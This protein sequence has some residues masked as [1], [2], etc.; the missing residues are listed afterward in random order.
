[1]K[2]IVMAGRNVFRHT[3]RSVITALAISVGLAGM[4]AMDTL[5][6]GADKMGMKNIVD[7]ETGQLEIFAKGYYREEGAYPLDTVIKDAGPLTAAVTGMPGVKAAVGRLKFAAR[8]SNGVDELPV[9]GIG[10]DRERDATVFRIPSAVVA[11]A[12]LDGP[13]QALIG[14]DLARDMKVGVGDILTVLV[15]DR[16]GT[17]NAIDLEVHGLL[18]TGHPLLDRNAVLMD[19]GAAQRLMAMPGWITELCVRTAEAPKRIA[20]IRAEIRSRIGPGY[21]IYAWDELNA[22]IFRIMGI[23]RFFG[24]LVGLAV[25]I[26]AAVGIINTMLMAV[27]ERVPEIGT[28]KALGF[29]NRSI[30]MMF[31]FE[32]GLIGAIGS[33][34]GTSVGL[35]ISIYL[36]TVGLDLSRKLGNADLNFPMKMI[37][38][39]EI[40]LSTILLVFAFGVAISVLVT[41]LPVRRAT[42]LEPADALRHV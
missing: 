26:I 40:N 34:V 15:R 14:A 11:G 25:L 37:F 27:M 16:N 18:V 32:G 35:I 20:E 2:L 7:Y 13:D 33:L 19:L 17:Y 31:L 38:R 23:K 12:Y 28:L 39:G 1:M 3:R 9:T 30:V 6:N 42:K 24:F 8:L 36:S 4:I 10:I 41:L 5:M 22:A 21:E 29:P